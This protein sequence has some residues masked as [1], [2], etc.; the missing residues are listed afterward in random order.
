MRAQLTAPRA[1]RRS[2]RVRASEHDPASVSPLPKLDPH[3]CLAPQGSTLQSAENEGCAR[4][5]EH[6]RNQKQR[7]PPP[8]RQLGPQH[9]ALKQVR[10]TDKGSDLRNVTRGSPER[11]HLDTPCHGRP[12]ANG[13]ANQTKG[14]NG[15]H[16]TKRR[17]RR[18]AIRQLARPGP[19][20]VRL[21]IRTFRPSVP[22][23]AFLVSAGDLPLTSMNTGRPCRPHATQP[24]LLG[25]WAQQWAQRRPKPPVPRQCARADSASDLPLLPC[26]GRVS[27]LLAEPP[28]VGRCRPCRTAVT[29]G[30]TGGQG[31]GR[32]ADLPI[33]SRTLVPTELPGR[34][35]MPGG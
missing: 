26:D 16:W 32:T 25:G 1:P 27:N 7:H 15:R 9:H 21:R 28:S 4:Q 10:K 19:P 23:V 18:A 17:L 31:R 34:G 13:N 14:R 24:H 2:L 5:P 35:R 6:E 11:K 20:T 30:F 29:C 22:Q 33:F 12:V 3:S 8:E